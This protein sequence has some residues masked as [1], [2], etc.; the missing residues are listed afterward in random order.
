MTYGQ[1]LVE[2]FLKNKREMPWR[3]TSDPYAIWVSEVMLQQTQ[4][5]TVIPYYERF[6]ERFST[7]N[8]LAKADLEEVFKYWQGLGYYRR[9]ENLHKGAKMIVT[10]FNGE[11]PQNPKLASKI[12]SVGDYTLGA[13]LSIAFHLP[14][15]AVDGNVMRILARAFLIE[16][17]IA[18]AKNKKIFK[19]KV[20]ELMTEDPNPF[21]QGL[22]E[23]GALVCTPQNPKCT[24]CPVKTV[25]KAYETDRVGELPVKAKKA[26]SPTEKYTLLL[27]KKEDKYWLEKRSG[28]GLLAN[29]WGIPMVTNDVFKEYKIAK[30]EIKKLDKVNH[31]FTHK[32]WEMQPVVLEYTNCKEALVSDIMKNEGSFIKIE[33][34]GEYPIATAFKKVITQL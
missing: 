9:A 18:N 17:D 4:V 7:V 8:D 25:C 29:L 1:M 16:E 3:N 10:E 11:F 32:K 12:P 23:L 19:D 27:I 2:W 6:M 14:I 24:S 28:E 34:M 15:P 30:D 20:L 22:M 13:V 31:I 26:K 5:N 33:E 21:N